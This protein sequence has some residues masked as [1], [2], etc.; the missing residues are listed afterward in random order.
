[1]KIRCSDRAMMGIAS[2]NPSYEKHESAEIPY[3]W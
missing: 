3:F 2:L 1:M